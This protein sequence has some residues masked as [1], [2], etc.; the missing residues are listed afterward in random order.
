MTEGVQIALITVVGPLLSVA[1]TAAMNFWQN[2]KN[3]MLDLHIEQYKTKTKEE[4]KEYSESIGQIYGDL[5]NLLY[6]YGFDRVYVVRPHPEKHYEFLSVQLEVRKNGVSS[7]KSIFQDQPM[8]EMP[9][10]CG[11]IAKEDYFVIPNTL[12][13]S[14]VQDVAARSIFARNGTHS[15]AV[16][17]LKDADGKWKG[18]IFCTSMS[19]RDL[20]DE[21]LKRDVLDTAAKIQLIIPPYKEYIA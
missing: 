15:A 16:A 11:M 1:I 21:K 3:K 4:A 17:K 14:N 2:K 5:W 9:Q 7:T 13:E 19:T 6:L 12:S 10:L 18:S 8:D 20:T